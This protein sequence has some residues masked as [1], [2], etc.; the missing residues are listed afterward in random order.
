M[1]L[2][3]IIHPEPES[4]DFDCFIC[5]NESCAPPT[6]YNCTQCDKKICDDCYRKHIL[7]SQ[8]CVFCRSQLNI[9]RY[10]L[11][12]FQRQRLY[13]YNKLMRVLIVVFIWY[14]LL[15]TYLYIISKLAS[16]K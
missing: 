4:N 1:N 12:Q 2:N 13:Y 3:L 10:R 7:T 5:C 16:K 9:T 15:L 8:L 11:S 6:E 14:T